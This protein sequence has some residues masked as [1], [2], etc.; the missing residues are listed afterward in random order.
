M[1]KIK[2]CTKC[3]LPETFPKIEFNK[4]GICNFCLSHE[5]LHAHGEAKLKKVLQAKKGKMYDCVVPISGGKD[6]IFVLNYAVKKLN[7]RVIAVNYDSGYQDSLSIENM[8]NACNILE[9]PLVVKKAKYNAQMIKS[10]I[11][12]SEIAG[13]FF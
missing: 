4:H 6:S 8:K 2:R 12:L 10:S 5:T 11:R 13:M 3:I 1:N 7:L 9:V